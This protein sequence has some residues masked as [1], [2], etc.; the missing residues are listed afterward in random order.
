M[1]LLLSQRSL[2]LGRP[3]DQNRPDFYREL[4]G[5]V[6]ITL[7]FR[8]QK[9][10]RLAKSK[11]CFQLSIPIPLRPF[12]SGARN[13]AVATRRRELTRAPR[14]GGAAYGLP[15]GSLVWLG[16][17]ATASPNLKP[18]TATATARRWATRQAPRASGPEFPTSCHSPRMSLL[19]SSAGRLPH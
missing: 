1:D 15:A 11:L 13:D 8:L 5:G 10:R 7:L 18:A 17:A 9:Y 19:C 2:V 6:I 14:G 12:S 3:N 16:P 4:M